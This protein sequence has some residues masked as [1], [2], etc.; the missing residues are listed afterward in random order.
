MVVSILGERYPV[1]I[2]PTAAARTRLDRA[3]ELV[4]RHIDRIRRATHEVEAQHL[5]VMAALA[6][7]DELLEAQAR[8]DETLAD[9]AAFRTAVRARGERLLA[10]VRRELDAA[11]RASGEPGASADETFSEYD[12]AIE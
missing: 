10:L 1:R 2:E 4:N 8:L 11:E 5:A 12:P 3:A 6:L 9:A 7:A